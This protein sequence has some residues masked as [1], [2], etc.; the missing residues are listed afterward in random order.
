MPG[1]DTLFDPITHTAF[2]LTSTLHGGIARQVC[3]IF[4]AVGG[5]GFPRVSQL[6]DIFALSKINKEVEKKEGNAI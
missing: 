3:P 1:H 6:T 4:P 5:G 2:P